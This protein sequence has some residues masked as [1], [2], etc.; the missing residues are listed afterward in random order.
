MPIDTLSV[1]LRKR[2]NKMAMEKSVTDS[3]SYS[4]WNGAAAV[5]VEK[6]QQIVEDLVKKGEITVEQGKELNKELQHNVKKSWDARKADASY[7]EENLK[8]GADELEAL[9]KAI[10]D[11]EN[12]A[13]ETITGLT[14]E[15]INAAKAE[16]EAQEQ[17]DE[18]LKEEGYAPSDENA[19]KAD[20]EYDQS[21]IEEVI[22]IE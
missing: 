21:T 12:A 18:L 11:V 14:E 7:F 4:W 9:K 17:L 5:T 22:R 6:S 19:Q 16:A 20:R 3:K 8:M 15:Q 1:S 13:T 10:H 2:G